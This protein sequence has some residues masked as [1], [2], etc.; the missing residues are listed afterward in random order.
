MRSFLL[1]LSLLASPL[2]AAVAGTIDTAPWESVAA[3]HDTRFPGDPAT[4][5]VVVLAED[6]DVAKAMP[7]KPVVTVR[8]PRAVGVYQL[9]KGDAAVTLLIPPGKNVAGKSGGTVEVL[10][11]GDDGVQVKIDA[12]FGGAGKG[13]V[14]GDFK[15]VPKAD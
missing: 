9:G 15:F 14:K 3:K 6:I 4:W 12:E 7:S 5:R 8:V 1:F 13:T 10:S 2:S 11:I